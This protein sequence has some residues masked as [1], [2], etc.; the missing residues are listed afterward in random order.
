MAAL[1]AV[2]AELDGLED[3]EQLHSTG[4]CIYR[5]GCML[6][7]LSVMVSAQ[8]TGSG[9]EWVWPDGHRGGPDGYSP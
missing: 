3:E 6:C 1:R 2:H 8:R 9:N 5:L 4:E 7:V